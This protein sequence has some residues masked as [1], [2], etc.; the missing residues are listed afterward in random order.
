[1]LLIKIKNAM[2]KYYLSIILFSLLLSCKQIEQNHIS[3]NMSFCKIY[4]TDFESLQRR[5]TSA[6]EIRDTTNNGTGSKTFLVANLDDIKSL[7]LHL[8]NS[9]LAKP[10][11]EKYGYDIRLVLDIYVDKNKTYSYEFA[12][13]TLYWHEE[14]LYEC[15]K[16]LLRYLSKYNANVK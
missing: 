7:F 12:D 2:I 9:K 15:D 11:D 8:K 4:H 3:Q 13:S 1:M 6:D 16:A 10:E 5:P 14:K